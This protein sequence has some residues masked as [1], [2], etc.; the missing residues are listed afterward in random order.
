M[1]TPPK[2]S[3]QTAQQ[4]LAIAHQFRLGELVTEQPHPLTTDL[5]GLAQN[6][7]ASA[8]R[9][10]HSIDLH[11]LDVLQKMSDSIY[12][13]ASAISE[14]IRNGHSVFLCGCGATGRLSLSCEMLWRTQYC[15]TQ[16]E[17]CVQSFMAGGDV[18][19]V[20]SIENF[21]DHPEYGQRQ[22]DDADFKNGDL[23]IST[24]EGGET[25]F[26]IGATLHAAERSHNQPFFLYCNPD[27]ILCSV[28]QRSKEVL[29]DT[30]IQKINCTVGPMAIAGSTRMQ[31]STILMAIVGYALLNHAEPEKALNEISL[32]RSLWKDIGI[33][34]LE[35][36]ILAESLCYAQNN[37]IMYAVDKSYA[38]CAITDTTERSPT[39]SLHP[40]EQSDAVAS[41]LSLCYAMIR[42]TNT[43]KDAWQTLLC[44]S[45]RPLDWHDTGTIASLERLKLF[46]FSPVS[47]NRRKKTTP[48]AAH[49]IFDIC[50]KNTLLY[51]KL[52]NC[53]EAFNVQGLSLLS[54]HLILKMLL[55]TH[56]TLVMG[57]LGRYQGNIMTWVRPSNN[58]LIDRA[59]RCIDLILRQKGILLSYEQLAYSCF[60]SMN[61]IKGDESLV[62]AVVKN[63]SIKE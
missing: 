38:I 53:E 16:W 49:H 37:Y 31:A 39:F 56:S 1:E 15:G 13:L 8:L 2:R 42:D 28:A 51:F 55:N 43:A 34:R 17:H 48:H 9:K 36:F 46:D 54:R 29:E 50:E 58:K 40:F 23:L 5:S 32:V 19:L 26:V 61:D 44:R 18:A 21:E 12:R 11:T 20:R 14:T 35:K 45:P 7:V 3:S 22:L 10:L 6:D 62:L 60:D 52:G 41:Q 63:L 57:R 30:R 25:P 27:Q 24:T 33:E 59:I 47:L 4:F